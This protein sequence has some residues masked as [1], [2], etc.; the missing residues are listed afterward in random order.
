[1]HWIFRAGLAC[2]ALLFVAGAT[3]AEPVGSAFNFS[4]QLRENGNPVTGAYDFHV[5]LF[6]D[7]AAGTSIASV[8]FANVQIENGT[9]TL[10]IDFTG[11][12]FDTGEL[13]YLEV[14]VRPGGSVDPFQTM[15]PRSAIRPVPY[16]I[17]ALSVAPGAV[18]DLEID[19]AS[20]QRRI[21]ASCP[22]DQSIRAIGADG[23]VTCEV[24]TVGSGTV[25]SVNAGSGVAVTNATTNPTV[26]IALAGIQRSMIAANAVGSAEVDSSTVQL[27]IADSCATDEFMR[28]VSSEGDPVC[29]PIHP[30][31]PP[32]PAIG[33]NIRT[34]LGSGCSG[35]GFT[36]RMARGS[37]GL[38]LVL[39]QQLC[40]DRASN[41][42]R[43]NDA[44]CAFRS[45][46][47]LDS[48]FGPDSTRNNAAIA[49]GPG[50]IVALALGRDSLRYQ[51]CLQPNC[52]ADALSPLVT[53]DVAT[54]GYAVD[55]AFA[56]DGLPIIVY[57]GP[58][59]NTLRTLKCT[60]LD[61]TT[62][63]AAALSAIATSAGERDVAI[64]TS[65]FSPPAIAF[66]G[67]QINGSPRALFVRCATGSCGSTT[68]AAVEYAPGA[69][70]VTVGIVIPSDDR[71]V[72]SHYDIDNLDLLVTRCGDSNCSTGNVTT[73]VAEVGATGYGT[74]IALIGG[75]P[76]VSYIDTTASRVMVVRCG[77][78][79][80]SSGN[81]FGVAGQ[82]V[83]SLTGTSL[84]VD[85]NGRPNV[86]AGDSS[87][88]YFYR[89]ANVAC[90]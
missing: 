21:Q 5:S 29:E 24:D 54:G 12:A 10:P 62:R 28:G 81:S 40:G 55:V 27:R 49:S 16:A 13:Y 85:P 88:V 9:F 11:A 3:T 1:M 53:L 22:A 7:P 31:P 30:P 34:P 84:I 61:C 72:I 39:S 73:V 59:D 45:I 26:G 57:I 80:C 65:A 60:N 4:G 25:T 87:Q 2:L 37:S 14:G 71:P 47:R 6:L 8:Q 19:S 42:V 83:T 33:A 48:T 46:L 77:N 20:V 35:F 89:C 76:V 32:P 56:D 78:L 58:T 75:L 82:E 90:D 44:S 68:G 51:R 79:E 52:G 41:I 70:G 36:Y 50:G 38:P 74:D 64:A 43:C 18:T 66:V 23:S 67:R 86:T 63:Q 69:K 15:T 17:E